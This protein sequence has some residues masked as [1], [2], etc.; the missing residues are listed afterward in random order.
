MLEW[1]K[2]Q[3]GGH[4]FQNRAG[5]TSPHLNLLVD[6]LRQLDTVRAGLSGR[7]TRYVLDHEGA[8]V[9]LELGGLKGCGTAL[10][11]SCCARFGLSK[12]KNQSRQQ[13]LGTTEYSDAHFYLRLAK[14]Y[15]AAA[16]REQ[17]HFLF[18]TLSGGAE[19]MEI[20][21]REATMP[22]PNTW[23]RKHLPP[24]LPID[25]FEA[26]LVADD[27]PADLLMR[28]AFLPDLKHNYSLHLSGLFTCLKGF[29]ENV[30]KHPQVVIETMNQKDFNLRVHALHLLSKYQVPSEIFA[31]QIVELA[32]SQSKQVREAAEV[33]LNRIPET[34]VPLIE[35]MTIEGTNEQRAL[36]VR[37]LW[38]TQGETC[39]SF[40]ESR[41]ER[42]SS[43]KVAQ[44]IRDLLTVPATTAVTA[45]EPAIELPPL[46]P[47]KVRAPLGDEARAVLI[48]CYEE[49]NHEAKQAHA[50]HVATSKGQ[51]K[52]APPWLVTRSNLDQGFELLECMTCSKIQI[53]PIL[54][55]P[56]WSS[57]LKGIKTFLARPEVEL[58]H[59][60]RLLILMGIIHPWDE[61][62]RR[63]LSWNYDQLLNHYRRHHRPPFGMRELAAV[64]KA[65]GLDD[66]VIGWAKVDASYRPVMQW[67]TDA[68]WPYFAERVN[69][70]QEAFQN[71]STGE[72]FEDYLR[73][74]RRINA[75]E[76]LA[77]FPQLPPVF[78]PML[79]EVALGSS[80]TERPLAQQCLDKLPGK[81]EKIVNALAS[82][83]QETR[84]VAAEWLGRLKTPEA[85][86]HL[87]AALKKEKSEVAKG[88]MMGALEAM[89]V[90]IEQFL[91]R[92]SLVKEAQKGLAKGV[93]PGLSW[94]PFQLLPAAHWED[95]GAPVPAEVL[96]WFIVQ[97]YKLKSAEP[98]PL[99]RRYCS[100]FRKHEREAL[101]QFILQ[102]WIAQDTLP[103]HTHE[104]AAQL[105]EQ[106]AN[107]SLSFWTQYAQRHAKLNPTQPVAQAPTK[108][109]LYRQFLN[110]L[111]SKCKASAIDQKGVLALAGACC[112][113]PA[114][115]VVK[116]YLKEW[117]GIRGAQCKALIQMLAWVEHP[118][119]IQLLLSVGNRFRTK[120][121]REEAEK[122]VQL[123]AERKGWTRDELADRTIPTAGF[124]EEGKLE[125]DYGARKFFATLGPEFELVLTNEEGKAITSLPEPR[126]DEDVAKVKEAKQK[127]SAAR[128]ELKSV[129]QLQ[130]ER[131]YEA[132]CTQRSWP[133]HEWETYLNRHSIAGRYCQGLVWTAFRNDQAASTFRP[134]ADGSLTDCED[135]AV[136]VEPNA[137]I[138]LAHDCNT[139]EALRRGWRQH[140]SDYNVAPLFEQFDKQGYTLSEENKGE[141]TITGFEGHLVEAFKLRGRATK[142]GY[143]RGQAQDGGWFFEYKKNFPSLGLEAIVEFTGNG[144]PEEN[145]T[146]ALRNLRFER[147]ATG[148]STESEG[149]PL[150][151]IP[152]VLLSECWND[153]RLAAAEGT[154]FDPDWEKK[155]AY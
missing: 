113:A 114:V 148:E 130:K 115:P 18:P 83:Q 72:R 128:K 133:F 59:C 96:T 21:L 13:L 48:N 71:V 122:Y 4:D 11:L 17:N 82:G 35:K 42:D 105:A 147:R 116:R 135:N 32:V 39:R 123:L 66:T 50:R 44:I 40:L 36:A 119:A 7:A 51:H 110:G 87:Q 78:L 117:Y 140:F 6:D 91:D 102:S 86:P 53:Q 73:R 70:L 85:I 93:P 33:V 64:F 9:L 79:W 118:A 41:I 12:N 142:L 28:A 5:L 152:P 132:M 52:A 95:T 98:N 27:R 76:I 141:T 121:I 23:P 56:A 58:I 106:Q 144:L 153:L 43:K 62:Q 129:L 2:A 90:P 38:A 103:A 1:L 101:G 155:T 124:D 145:R 120:G 57:G 88:A 69:L 15:E 8:E 84:A 134:L 77:M 67:E 25:V 20:L 150:G 92:A 37:R 74:D 63:I 46:P 80:K 10:D 104:E 47:V 94:V 137:V 65:I 54:R 146:V 127:L 138:R 154:G 111:L 143:T 108:D 34:A 149:V 60:T 29:A 126:Q 14:V 97:G 139:T 99:L 100:Y 131:L 151:E 45:Q 112:G 81:E 107:R 68:I 55:L 61:N 19:W 26:M 3:F 31:G 49:A 30:L 16:R 109:D 89:G 22:K 75:F 125:I 24:A 136:S